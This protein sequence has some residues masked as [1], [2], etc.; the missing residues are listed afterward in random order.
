MTPE[1]KAALT[2]AAMIQPRE[3][4][5]RVVPRF[6]AK[7]LVEVHGGINQVVE[8]PGGEMVPHMAFAGDGFEVFTVHDDIHASPPPRGYFIQVGL[9]GDGAAFRLDDAA[10]LRAFH[11]RVRHALD[12]LLLA[13]LLAT[14]Q[15]KG[16]MEHVIVQEQDLKWLKLARR[17]VT[18]LPGFTLPVRAGAADAART[19]W[20]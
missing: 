19:R 7:Y 5:G 9:L 11:Q 12:P 4:I 10:Q 2:V 6:P 20:I 8:L 3:K 15:S 18:S 17:D 13:H 16:T 1:E 14:N